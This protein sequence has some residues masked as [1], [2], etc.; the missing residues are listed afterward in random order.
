MENN[1]SE[2]LK[3]QITK[4]EEDNENT[5]TS[6]MA[7]KSQHHTD[8][9]NHTLTLST[10]ALG[11]IFGIL[12]ISK[13]SCT[14]P[15][16]A[17]VIFFVLAIVATMWSY[18]SADNTFNLSSEAYDE[19]AD[20]IYNLREVNGDYPD[21]GNEAETRVALLINQHNEYL[22]KQKIKYTDNVTVT[23]WLN[24]LKTFS[25]VT[26]VCLTGIAVFL[27]R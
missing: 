24:R 16:W 10:A 11:L 25:F 26:G 23:R 6:S 9:D 18:I 8:W 19:K 14:W 13:W 27:N 15:V 7:S 4:I 12:P 2:E 3:A 1:F 22:A 20:L 5:L 21:G 17:A